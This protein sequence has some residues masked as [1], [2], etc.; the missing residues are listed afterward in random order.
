M[1][2]KVSAAEYIKGGNYDN[3]EEPTEVYDSIR[4]EL[5]SIGLQW[6]VAVKDLDTV[7]MFSDNSLLHVS[8]AGSVTIV[9]QMPKGFKWQM[10]R[11]LI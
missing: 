2:T 10:L 4:K 3:P 9:D 11:P 5:D 8:Q 6:S 7:L 1:I